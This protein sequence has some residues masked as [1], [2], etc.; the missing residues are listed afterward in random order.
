MKAVTIKIITTQT[1]DQQPERFTTKVQGHLWATAEAYHLTYDLPREDGEATHTTLTVDKHTPLAVMEH[2]GRMVIEEHRTH[3]GP[4]RM[5]PYEMEMAVTGKQVLCRM[6][7]TGGNI[8]LQYELAINGTA[9]GQ[10]TVE[11]FVEQ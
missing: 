10:T 4:Y 8:R 11:L 2:T 3:T 1:V 7:P 5:G 6:S 9:A